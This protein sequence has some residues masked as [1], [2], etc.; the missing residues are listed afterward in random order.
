MEP[1]YLEIR[2]VHIVSVIASGVLLLV[3]GISFNLL[4]ASWAVSWPVRYLAYSVDTVLLTA[5]LMLMTIVKQYPFADSWLTVKLLLVLLYFALSYSALG[6]ER[7]KTRWLCL[8]GAVPI[9][10]FIVTVARAHHPLGL[11]A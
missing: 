5:A 7:E 10:G 9:F 1:F 6:A 8:A 4:N 2:T 11:L 3:R